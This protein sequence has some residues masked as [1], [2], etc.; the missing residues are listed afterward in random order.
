MPCTVFAVNLP[1]SRW[2]LCNLHDQ[3]HRYVASQFSSSFCFSTVKLLTISVTMSLGTTG[4]HRSLSSTS[5]MVSRIAELKTPFRAHLGMHLIKCVWT[6]LPMKLL[7]DKDIKIW[8]QQHHS[9]QHH[10][11]QLKVAYRMQRMQEEGCWQ[12]RGRKN[13]KAQANLL[14]VKATLQ[15]QA[16]KWW[17]DMKITWR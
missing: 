14:L 13:L 5:T 1:I 17:H 11:Q 4:V 9:E 2:K 6:C 12:H 3:P 10:E 8:R 16:M 15:T 7:V